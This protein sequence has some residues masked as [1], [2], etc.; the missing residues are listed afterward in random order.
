M[1]R[2]SLTTAVVAGIAGVAGFASIA[3]AVDLNPD[4]L[5]QVLIYPYYTV[6]KNQATAISVVNTT[7]TAKS[8]KVRFLEGYDSRE[9]LDFNLFLSKYDVWT[10][11]V[12]DLGPALGTDPASS[13]AAITTSDNSC[14]APLIAN[15]DLPTIPGTDKHYQAFLTTAYQDD[16]GPTDVTRTREGHIEMIQMTDLDGPLGSAVTHSGGVPADCGAVQGLTAGD[17]NG[18]PDADPPTGGLFGAGAIFDVAGGVYYGYNADAVDGFTISS[19]FSGQESTTPQLADANTDTFGNATAYVFNNGS[20]IQSTYAAANAI[21][22]VSAVFDSFSIFNE[23]NVDADVGSNTDWVVTFPTKRFYVDPDIVGSTAIPPFS[24][25]FDGLS[26]SVVGISIYDREERTT[27]GPGPGFSPPPPGQPPSSLC[28]ET[29]IISFLATSAEGAGT[30][31]GVFGS[32]L[33]TNIPPFARSGWVELN[34]DPNQTTDPHALRPSTDGDIF[35]GLPATGFAAVSYINGEVTPGTLAN[36]SG[37]FRH[38]ASRACGNP[39]NAGDVC[40]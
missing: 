25:V 30:I 12:F 24:Q 39:A 29:N 22:A 1:K 27:V 10:A 2:N 34:L 5:G 26:C 21:D 28:R 35:H 37:L 14:T 15:S 31:S 13:G 40:S 11:S 9:V 8:V 7:A 17:V 33:V 18:T 16:G 38:R 32:A 20:L 4:G 6:N 19:L 23:Y 36:Y 3:S